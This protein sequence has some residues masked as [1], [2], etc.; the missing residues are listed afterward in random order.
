M[1]YN[2]GLAQRKF[3]EDWKKLR[4]EY[5]AAGMREDAIDAMEAF[6][7][8]CLN[9]DR[10]FYESTQPMDF[11]KVDSDVEENRS[12]SYQQK[13]GERLHVEARITDPDRRH[14]WIDELDDEELVKLVKA[15]PER[16]LEFL[17]MHIFEGYSQDEIAE[18][19][20]ISRQFVTKRIMK[21]RKKL[22][23]I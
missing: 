5:R 18:I 2:N 20:G 15:L 8:E 19:S 10:R 12:K 17:T 13:F 16:D 14:A 4:K 3:K 23:K 21:L 1:A 11:C 6:D 7:R 9:G 22:K